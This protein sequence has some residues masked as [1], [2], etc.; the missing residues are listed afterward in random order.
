MIKLYIAD[1]HQMFIDGISALLS[2]G[3]AATVTGSASSG[4]ELLKALTTAQ[5]EL[6]LMDIQM[7]DM[8][9]IEAT[10]QVK[11]SYPNIK[12]IILSMLDD[13]KSI[14]QATAAGADGYILKNTGRE[15]LERAIQTVMAGK[16][17]Y[18]QPITD[19]LIQN[20]HTPEGKERTAQA[21]VLTR[22]EKEVLIE[23]VNELTTAEIADKLFVS[24]NTVETHRKN[25]L[26]KTGAKNSVGLVKVAMGLGLV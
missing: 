10:T 13:L 14:E 11:A 23:I 6:I 17:F 4:E 1:D 26:S 24:V 2:E 22:R 16:S 8:D 9:G 3:E 15:E 25:L 19:A 7:P 20:L 12:V 5:P 21:V 18:S